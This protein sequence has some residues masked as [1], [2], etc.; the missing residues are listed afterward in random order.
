[1]H[2]KEGL[3]ACGMSGAALS[4]ML[5]ITK[6][7]IGTCYVLGDLLYNTLEKIHKYLSYDRMIV[8]EY[9]MHLLVS[10]K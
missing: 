4:S 8:N 2:T 3:R 9:G 1:M 5:P 7:G 6:E 10:F